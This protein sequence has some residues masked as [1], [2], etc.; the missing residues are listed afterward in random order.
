MAGVILRTAAGT[1]LFVAFLWL[2]RIDDWRVA[3]MMLTFP[4]LNGMALV[5][6]REHARKTGE[7]MVPI[8]TLN[9]AMCFLLALALAWSDTARAHPLALTL[10]AGVV[11]LC[12]YLVLEARNVEVPWGWAIFSF[13]VA[14]VAASVAITIWLWPA[15]TTLATEIPVRAGGLTGVLES[16]IRIVLFALSLL[17][18]FVVAHFYRDAHAAI[19]RLGALPVVPLFGLY[20][21]GSV[22]ASDPAAIPKL[23]SMRSMVLVGWMFALVFAVV[24]A[25]YVA[26]TSS[27]RSGTL[28]HLAAL[29]VGWA[30]C[31]AGIVASAKIVTTLSGCSQGEGTAGQHRASLTVCG[32][33]RFVVH[34]YRQRIDGLSVFMDLKVKVGTAAQAGR[35]DLADERAERDTVAHAGFNAG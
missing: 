9:G 6:A 31:L 16:W 20:T 11:W 10:L 25:A 5:S 8:V 21:V 3:G 12:V 14:C 15:C 23:E 22:L 35:A 34:S 4:M 32:F 7:S 27:P 24:L 29:V 18:V 26:R 19:G 17:L 30:I 2:V 1:A 13:T 33:E 28:G